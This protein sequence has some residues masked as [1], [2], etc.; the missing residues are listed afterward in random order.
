MLFHTIYTCSINRYGIIDDYPKAILRISIWLPQFI[1]HKAVN[2]LIHNISKLISLK[3]TVDV[4]EEQQYT[5]KNLEIR[6][7]LYIVLYDVLRSSRIAKPP[8]EILQIYKK[9][10]KKD[11]KFNDLS[12]ILSK[13]KAL[14]TRLKGHIS[15]LKDMDVLKT[16]F[17]T[18]IIR[19]EG[20]LGYKIGEEMLYK[21]PH[22]HKEI[23]RI[24]NDRK[25]QSP[26]T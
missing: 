15:A 19:M 13:V 26:N 16:D 10:F 22:Y 5:I 20:T 2:R 23:E 24:A 9:H 25:K 1:I 11:F 14:K 21:L 8:L 18:S 17:T 6:I 7:S 3:E 4:R 12:D